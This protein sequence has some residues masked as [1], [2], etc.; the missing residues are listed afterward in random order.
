MYPSH[1]LQPMLMNNQ[2]QNK[3]SAIKHLDIAR[4]IHPKHT[5][6]APQVADGLSY[7]LVNDIGAWSQLRPSHACHPPTESPD[8]CDSIL[9]H[10][11]HSSGRIP[12]NRDD[13]CTAWHWP[14]DPVNDGESTGGRISGVIDRSFTWARLAAK[15]K[16]LCNLNDCGVEV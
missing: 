8:W 14:G 7:D 15:A 11:G 9:N 5:S 2:Y 3:K 16:N 10:I 4:G 6:T 1:E 13:C 12:N